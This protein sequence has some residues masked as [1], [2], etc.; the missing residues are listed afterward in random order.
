MRT[1][2][3]R[4]AA[5][6]VFSALAVSLPAF[7]ET[8][9]VL[10]SEVAWG[11]TSKSIAD[12]WI[13]LAPV[14]ADP[15]SLSGWT[16]EGAL[17]GGNIL[18]LP[19]VTLLPGSTYVITNY[20]AGHASTALAIAPSF[21]TT[22]VSLPN[23]GLRLILKRPDGT[24]VDTAGDG[25]KPPAGVSGS[26]SM[27]R[28][29]IATWKTADTTSGYA[30][31]LPDFGT[32]GTADMTPPQTLPSIEGEGDAVTDISEEEMPVVVEEVPVVE[33]IPVVSSV[34][35]ALHVP[36]GS[37]IIN[38]LLADPA[39]GE[40]EWIELFNPFVNT[41]PMSGWSLLDKGG[42]KTPLPDVYLGFGQY[43][44]IRNPVGNLNN[45]SDL[46]EL[47]GPD[48]SV[49]DTVV[50]GANLIP[51][52]KKGQALGR[53]VD[54][55]WGHS[56]PMTPGA[57][58]IVPVPVL[59]MVETTSGTHSPVFETPSVIDSSPLSLSSHGGEG[60]AAASMSVGT[61]ILSELYP[62]TG[63]ND[64]A[65]EF[66]EVRNVGAEEA[67]FQGW[68]L[69]DLSKTSYV[70]K[71]ETVLRPQESLALPRS[72][73]KIALN[74][75]GDTVRLSAPDASERDSVVY[76]KA[77]RKH[78]YAKQL[79]GTW[80]WTEPTPDE[81][82]SVPTV[83]VPDVKPVAKPKATPPAAVRLSIADAREAEDGLRVS[84]SG[85]VTHVAGKVAYLR[86]ESGGLRVD[87]SKVFAF[88]PGDMVALSGAVGTAYGERRVRLGTKDLA[89]VMGTTPLPTA[90]SV[91]AFT[92]Q[93]I[94]R[95]VTLEGFL[96]SKTATSL[97]ADFNG[98]ELSVKLA[99]DVSLSGFKTGARIHLTGIAYEK[100]GA[101]ALL[102][103][104]VEA[105]KEQPAPVATPVARPARGFVS[106]FTRLFRRT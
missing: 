20:P 91:T 66:I 19:D 104:T 4:I 86:D 106:F 87:S 6:T 51:K 53:R 41:L 81:E 14:G 23:E 50:Y 16:L 26:A 22:S 25:G 57:E 15:V 35:V 88:K 80:A 83:V 102:S 44:V 3:L 28:A 37:V 77:T 33:E 58:N 34:A 78:T 69:G 72:L 32:P 11:G 60:G 79:D 5:G 52:S 39:E 97:K 94:G 27:I 95:L 59:V 90:V 30:A 73:T 67:N 54:G 96:L 93:D 105:I 100:E 99:P 17:S 18:T 7:A 55:T 61:F 48:G 84:I 45:G 2:A 13:E 36:P 10:I 40:N 1:Y 9:T 85:T 42:G 8:P 103:A 98:D 92:E 82:N 75:T 56:E 47:V 62:N 64:V 12:E 21:T 65:E 24:V 71:D 89:R 38:E 49:V 74:N 29:D 76:E 68:R 46:I 31:G 63:G 70:H 43:L 101:F